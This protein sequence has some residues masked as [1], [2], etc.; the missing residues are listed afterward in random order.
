MSPVG[1]GT[2]EALAVDA[3]EGAAEVADLVDGLVAP[4]VAPPCALPLPPLLP[5]PV[6]AAA[7]P[8]QPASAPVRVMRAVAVAARIRR[9]GPPARRP[10]TPPGLS[11][12]DRIITPR[13]LNFTVSARRVGGKQ[14]A[15]GG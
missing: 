5:L 11:A 4:V 15:A 13:V 10:R 6:T 9:C 3:P 12:D 7:P 14:R 8:E 1:I 2:A